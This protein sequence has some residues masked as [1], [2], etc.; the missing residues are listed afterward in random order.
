MADLGREEGWVN[1]VCVRDLERAGEDEAGEGLRAGGM[2]GSF[3]LDCAFAIMFDAAARG[4]G[5]SALEGGDSERFFAAREEDGPEL[6]ESD[7]PGWVVGGR[8]GGGGGAQYDTDMGDDCVRTL[9]SDI[10]AES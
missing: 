9:D 4:V 7:V 1:P 10:V 3:H 2:R 6:I 8:R 5:K